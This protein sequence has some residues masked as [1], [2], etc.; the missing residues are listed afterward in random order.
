MPCPTTSRSPTLSLR[1]SANLPLWLS[2]V[3]SLLPRSLSHFPLPRRTARFLEEELARRYREAA[4]ATLALLQDNGD[5]MD[6]CPI[7]L[8]LKTQMYQCVGQLT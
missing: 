3:P 4:P 2:C 5:Y 7:N 1:S 6:P 8:S